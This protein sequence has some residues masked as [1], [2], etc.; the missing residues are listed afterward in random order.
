M[1]ALGLHHYNLRG[2][3]EL[4]ECLRDFYRRTLGLT[5]GPRPPFNSKGYW[6]YA[7][8]RDVLHLTVAA[9][10]EPDSAPRAAVL[11]HIAFECTGFEAMR[12]RLDAHGVVY[13]VDE[14]PQLRQ[15]QIFF[16]DPAGTGVELTF[17]NSDQ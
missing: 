16:N 1:A 14:V 2:P 4:V 9:G 17:T 13:S 12:A 5:S 11:D 6:L 10:M 3:H 8:D 15:R 7:G